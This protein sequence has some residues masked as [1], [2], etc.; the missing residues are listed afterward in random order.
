M[1]HD[2]CFIFITAFAF[3]GLYC[4]IDAFVMAT[5]NF[6]SPHTV[7]IMQYTGHRDMYGAISYIHNTLYNNE[8]ILVAEDASIQCPL[9]Q[10]VTAEE[11]HKYITI[12]LFTKN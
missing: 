3:F 1:L 5:K 2:V 10:T 4:F 8:I 7:T 6:H 12:A 9:A 11:L